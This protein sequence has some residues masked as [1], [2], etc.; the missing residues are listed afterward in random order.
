MTYGSAGVGSG[1]HLMMERLSQTIDIK[2]NHIPYQGSGAARAGLVAGEVPAMFASVATAKQSVEEGSLIA[3]GISSAER[4]P[5]LPDV[6][7][8]SELGFPDF[9]VNHWYAVLGPAGMPSD[10]IQEIQ[11]TIDKIMADPDRAGRFQA[12]GFATQTPVLTPA[13]FSNTIASDLQKWQGV[14]MNAGIQG[15]K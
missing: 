4:S 8:F 9:V 12:L 3:I 14:I 10:A 13:E 2:L 5:E 1:G 11:A 6:P 7:T 15:T